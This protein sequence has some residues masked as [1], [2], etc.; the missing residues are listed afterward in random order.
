[1]VIA[2]QNE[3][4]EAVEIDGEPHVVFRPLVEALGLDFASQLTKLK[5][6]SWACVAKIAT[7]LPGDTQRR[8]HIVVNLK[9]L[10]R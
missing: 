2:Y 7:R 4:A 5:G 1:M 6:K 3:V 10:K 9:T 8:E